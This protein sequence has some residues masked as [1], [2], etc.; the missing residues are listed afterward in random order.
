M[1]TS[2]GLDTCLAFINCQI[3]PAVRGQPARSKL[4]VTISRQAGAGATEVARRLA[5]Y[6]ERHA[7][8]EGCPWTV[9]DRNLVEKV[10]EDH[11]L[12]AKLAQFMPEDRVSAIDDIM[13]E[14]LGLHPPS[15]TLLRQTTE[16]ILKLAELGNVILVGRGAHVITSRLAHVFHVRLVGSVENRVARLEREQGLAPKAALAHLEKEDRGRERY[17]REHFRAEADDPLLYHLI[18]NTDRMAGEAAAQLIGEAALRH[19]GAALPAGNVV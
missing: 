19:R 13:T 5:Q 15:W 8:A 4:A 1:H 11:K 18:V 14:I 2:L 7:P 6:L 16:T 3:K 10:L 9:F 12:P 17:L